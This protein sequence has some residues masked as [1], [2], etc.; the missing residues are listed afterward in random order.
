[1]N[2]YISRFAGILFLLL[3]L[4]FVPKAISLMLERHLSYLS[5]EE[6]I[7]VSTSFSSTA[8]CVLMSFSSLSDND[9]YPLYT[10]LFELA[11]F[12]CCLTSMTE[13]MSVALSSSGRQGLNMLVNTVYYLLGVSIAFTI[14]L[15][16]LLLIGNDDRPNLK[17]LRRLAVVLFI[18]D[19]LATL[20]NI[21]FGYFFTISENGMYQS[22]PTFWLSYLIPVAFIVLTVITAA[23]EMRPGRQRQ[24]FLYFWVFAVIFS[25]LQIWREKISVQY[26][27]YTLSLI[28]IYMNVQGELDSVCGITSDW[29][30]S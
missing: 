23:R 8:L 2:K 4:L 3:E 25:L 7:A 18:V 5:P 1:M 20:L 13:L 11:A 10:F 30:I 27:G 14:L 21:R 26:T 9:S 22:A 19:T 12:L 6:I 17:K 28:V 16:E 24:A 29:E 15:Y